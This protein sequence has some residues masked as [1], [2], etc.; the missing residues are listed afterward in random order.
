MV[1]GV[2]PVKAADNDNRAVGEVIKT[3]TATLWIGEDGIGRLAILHG[4]EETLEDVINNVEAGIKLDE[5]RK[6]PLLCDISGLKSISRE[7]REFYTGE[8][9]TKL[10][11]ASAILVDSQVGRLIGNF[12]IAVNRPS[13][14]TRI[15]ISESKAIEWLK[16]FA[17]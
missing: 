7:A 6:I 13:Y 16:G 12:F 11:S 5:G 15:F 10:V 8:E 9:T 14:P 2:C 3:R 1:E 17:R 4:A